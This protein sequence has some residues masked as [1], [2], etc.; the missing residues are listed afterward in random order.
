[1][2]VN[3]NFNIKNGLEVNQ[4]L[5]YADAGSQRVG[6]NTNTPEYSLHV[7]GGIGV[8]DISASGISTFGTVNISDA[9]ISTGIISATSLN[10]HSFNVIG[11]STFSHINLSGTVSIAGTSGVD[12]QILSTT[13][14][15]VTWK[16]V[17]PPR[18]S[19]VYSAGIG[20]TSFSVSYEVGLLD[21]YIN[22]VRLVPPPSAHA[23]FTASN[24]STVVLNDPCFG[25]EIVEF[26][27][28]NQL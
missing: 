15:G 17:V 8:T 13:G 26:V 5:V 22:G 20:S 1:M 14:T 19:V 9:N 18:T 2:A 4:D 3:K 12:G 23:E 16:T 27:V 28:Y 21:T 24:G 7:R 6:I 25:G 10:A 11:V